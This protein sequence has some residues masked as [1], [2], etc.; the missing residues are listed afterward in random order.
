MLYKLNLIPE[1]FKISINFA[2]AK[3]GKK[4]QL[5]GNNSTGLEISLNENV[6][7]N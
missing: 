1:S 7:N 6:S 4:E 2:V 5:K 3:F